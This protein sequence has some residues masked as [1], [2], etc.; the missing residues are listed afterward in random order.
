MWFNMEDNFEGQNT[1]TAGMP[2]LT[3]VTRIA[4]QY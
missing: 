3:S 1:E 2:Y 4:Q